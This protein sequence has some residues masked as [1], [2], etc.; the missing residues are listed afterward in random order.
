MCA[1]QSL[2]VERAVP[3]RLITAVKSGLAQIHGGTIRDTKTG[4]ILAHLVE[5]SGRLGS[6][7]STA[8]AKTLS[9]LASR[10]LIATALGTAAL[11]G[12]TLAVGTASWAFLANLPAPNGPR[13]GCPSSARVGKSTWVSREA[14]PPCYLPCSRLRTRLPAAPP[15]CRPRWN[16]ALDQGTTVRGSSERAHWGLSLRWTPPAA[17]PRWPSSHGPRLGSP[18]LAVGWVRGGAVLATP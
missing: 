4:R 5:V 14:V 13:L 17:I 8:G 6:T 3:L 11:S 15:P 1:L 7:G 12:L 10:Q 2:I 18:A 9:E 16:I